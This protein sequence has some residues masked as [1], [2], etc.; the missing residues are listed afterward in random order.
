MTLWTSGVFATTI[1]R[2]G[3]TSRPSSAAAADPSGSTPARYAAST[4]ARDHFRP[5]RVVAARH[6]LDLTV[7]VVGGDDAP[8]DQELLD[9][10]LHATVVTRAV[11]APK[12]AGVAHAACSSQC[13]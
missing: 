12:L 8:Q 2:S 13:W 9:R 7:D 10:R 11:S 5:A 6:R 4:H 1:R 3:P